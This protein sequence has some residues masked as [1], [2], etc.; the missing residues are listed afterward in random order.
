MVEVRCSV[1]SCYFW[2]AG[3]ACGAESIW[4]RRSTA[5][6]RAEAGRLEASGEFLAAADDAPLTSED[7]CCQ[8]YRPRQPRI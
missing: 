7:T 5:P 8:T 4:V 3:N 1:S 2:Q 6:V